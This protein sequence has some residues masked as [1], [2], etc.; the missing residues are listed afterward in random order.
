[1]KSGHLT[2][3]TKRA[4]PRLLARHL[5]TWSDLIERPIRQVH[6]LAAKDTK[7]SW[8]KATNILRWHTEN[9]RNT[10]ATRA[11]HT[12]ETRAK[13]AKHA[14]NNQKRARNTPTDGR[15]A[16]R[17]RCLRAESPPCFRDTLLSFQAKRRAKDSAFPQQFKRKVHILSISLSRTGRIPR[18]SPDFQTNNSH[19]RRDFVIHAADVRRLHICPKVEQHEHL[20]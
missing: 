1:L 13:H 19:Q 10:R 6:V 15:I 18:F 14:Q 20:V 9:A 4:A 7:G 8:E 17:S 12:R 16:P 11:K 5:C 2:R 3:N